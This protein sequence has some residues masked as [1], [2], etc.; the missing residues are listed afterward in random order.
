MRKGRKRKKESII[1][2]LSS[3]IILYQFHHL[4]SFKLKL[5]AQQLFRQ[6]N[7][8]SQQVKNTGVRALFAHHPLVLSAVLLYTPQCYDY[9]VVAVRQEGDATQMCVVSE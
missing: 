5:I 8:P 4:N 2:H 6:Q 1:Y 7:L 3:K 9:L